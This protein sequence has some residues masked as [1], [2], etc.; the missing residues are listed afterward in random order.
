V[1]I[2]LN[3]EPRTIPASASVRDL[4]RG[5]ALDEQAVAIERNR[6]IVAR[7]EWRGTMVRSGDR[8]EIVH[9]VGGG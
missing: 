3:G 4:I 8:I 6:E 1:S 2:T 9:F 7:P 5:L